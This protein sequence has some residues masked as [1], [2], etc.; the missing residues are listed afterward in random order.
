MALLPNT[1]NNH[2]VLLSKDTLDLVRAVEREKVRRSFVV[3]VMKNTLEW[4]PI[5]EFLKENWP[6]LQA[7]YY[8]N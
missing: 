2:I 8:K 7:N 5:V 6:S 3:A 1:E 4:E